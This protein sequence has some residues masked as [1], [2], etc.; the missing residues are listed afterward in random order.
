MKVIAIGRQNNGPSQ[1][2]IYRLFNVLLVLSCTFYA[3]R[4]EKAQAKCLQIRKRQEYF[5]ASEWEKMSTLLRCKVYTV[6]F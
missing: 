5:S 4:N 3:A 1:L 2:E 6:G